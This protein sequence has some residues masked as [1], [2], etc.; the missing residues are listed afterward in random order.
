MLD[1]LLLVLR[2]IIARPGV[3]KKTRRT[4]NRIAPAIVYRPQRQQGSEAMY[5]GI[6]G[7]ILLIII[8]IILFR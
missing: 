8:L 1:L 3:G 2:R 7:L 6:G 4:G 5:F